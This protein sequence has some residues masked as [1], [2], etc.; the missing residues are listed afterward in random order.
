MLKPVFTFPE[1]DPFR[2]I[3]AE[4]MKKMDRRLKLGLVVA[5]GALT[6]LLAACTPD[7]PQTEFSWDADEHVPVYHTAPAPKDQRQAPT[8]IYQG[9]NDAVP[10]PKPRPRY[11][12][13]SSQQEA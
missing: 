11:T 2:D 8:Y 10:T 13:S 9:D 4:G 1:H 5:L 6:P 3:R 7:T 12:P